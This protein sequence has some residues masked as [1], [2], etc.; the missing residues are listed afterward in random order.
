M[1]ER[2]RQWQRRNP[3][4]R[5]YRV[6]TLLLRT[7]YTIN[8]ERSR[9]VRAH[10]RGDFEVH[11]DVEALVRILRDFRLTAVELGGLLIKLGQF[12]GAR[13]DLLPEAAL[14]ELA[15]LHDDVPPER[16]ADVTTVLER[17]WHA[18]LSKICAAIE[19]QPAG[20]ASLGQVHEAWL[21]D[22]SHVAIKV[23]RPGI[24]AI[25][26]TDLRCL[27]FVLRVVGW[28]VPVAN[29]FTD[30]QALYREFSR[31]VAEELDYEQEARHAV[32]F[33]RLFADDASILV[34]AVVP[35]YTTRRVLVLE[36]MD[37]IKI[38][39]FS[40]LDAAGVDRDRLAKHLADAYFTQILMAGYFHADPHPGNLLVQPAGDGERIVFLDFGMMGDITPRMRTGLRECFHGAV[41]RDAARLVRGLDLLGLLADHA[42]RAAVE[43][44][45]GAMLQRFGGSPVRQLR[46]TD[47]RE[48]LGD[49]ERGLYD[50]PIRL[51]AE[52]AFFGRM[53]GMLL[54]LM[55]GLSPR[56]NFVDVATPY[57]RQ[58]LRRDGLEVVLSLLGVES[59]EGLGRDLL[60][61]GLATAR[62]LAGL[63][64][65]LD[66][67]LERAERGE[68]HV[69]IQN[70]EPPP[71]ARKQARR[72][73]TPQGLSRPVPLWMPLG[74][75]VLGALTWLVQRRPSAGR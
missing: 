64:Q 7:L 73:I 31:T 47:P 69:F 25:V 12:L 55:V 24:S 63:P 40:A 68:V 33:A 58:F 57:A 16:F 35:M 51:P 28:L 61:S 27:R 65:R 22:G 52:F 1:L 6:T 30:L 44:L 53:A 48:V 70:A 54:G 66:R 13:A 41:A 43:R 11:P 50:Q 9:V 39:D 17:A 56:F 38:T 29:R 15:G 5:S 21:T 32:R 14:N 62:S 10:A 67:V 19:P 45:V 72:R 23:Q 74:L 20:S 2:W 8:R 49:V 60:H 42:D 3:V 75:L 4:W 46:E 18:P 36:W 37:G 71:V 34:P 26:R 59:L